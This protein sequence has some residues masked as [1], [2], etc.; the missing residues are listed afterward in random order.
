MSTDGNNSVNSQ[1]W[2]DYS[3]D[4]PIFDTPVFDNTRDSTETIVSTI[5][6]LFLEF[7]KI[8]DIAVACQS[9]NYGSMEIKF[10]ELPIAIQNW[11]TSYPSEALQAFEAVATKSA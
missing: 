4:K 10:D 2:G 9:A 8:D 1:L 11:F 7:I 3:G 6:G 5:F